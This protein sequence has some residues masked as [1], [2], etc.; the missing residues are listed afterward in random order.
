MLDRERPVGK[1]SA[2]QEAVECQGAGG[3]QPAPVDD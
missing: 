1:F 2:S 3:S